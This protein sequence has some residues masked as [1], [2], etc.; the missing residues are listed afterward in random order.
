MKIW[1]GLAYNRRAT[2]VMVVGPL[3]ANS[4]L[5]CTQ[6]N[7]S[8]TPTIDAPIGSFESS[9]FTF[10]QDSCDTVPQMETPQ[11]FIRTDA[12]TNLSAAVAAIAEL[13]YTGANLVV[14]RHWLSRWHADLPPRRGSFDLSPIMQHR[15]S[16]I[17]CKVIKDQSITCLSAGSFVRLSLGQHLDGKDM[18]QLVPENLRKAKLDW[19]WQVAQGAVS[20]LRR[21]FR[22][23]NGVSATAQGIALPFSGE[24]ADGA[25][26]FL[27]HSN[28]H[29]EGNNWVVGDVKAE[30]NYPL[31][32]RVITFVQRA[33]SGDVVHL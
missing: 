3:C 13:R 33:T 7:V 25:R 10:R 19:A 17:F 4:G 32:R 29:P 24:D 1:S 21:Q 14:A 12:M 27:M 6:T 23:K 22:S 20:V 28:W 16:M 15:P 2:V 11:S 30:L 18:L 26:Q 5:G 8:V 9:I 31:D